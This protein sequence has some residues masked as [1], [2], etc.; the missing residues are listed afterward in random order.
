MMR[1]LPFLI[2]VFLFSC[3]KESRQDTIP[4]VIE[5]SPVIEVVAVQ[6]K[7][8]TPYE[9]RLLQKGFLDVEE[10]EGIRIELPYATTDN[11]VGEILYDSLHTAFL[12][13]L[14]Y[15]KLTEAQELLQEEHPNYSILIYDALRPNAVQHRM[16]DIVKGTEKERY[17]ASPWAGSIHNFGL[18]ID[19][20]IYNLDTNEL[21]EMGTDYDDLSS[22]AQYRYNDRLV[23]EGKIT[24]EAIE[25]RIILR[26]VMKE[27]GFQPINSEWWHFNAL[28]KTET[29]KQYEME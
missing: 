11:F 24:E 15:K 14:A 16:W 2:F 6:Q 19:C 9:Q 27:A 3:Q 26:K 20:T 22:L 10:I 18:A 4:P 12:R 25:N 13:P 17:V 29:R 23:K 21:L 7:E 8:Y 5:E 28:S 1:F